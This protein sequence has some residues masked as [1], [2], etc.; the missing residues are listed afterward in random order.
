[1]NATTIAKTVTKPYRDA[2]ARKA[3]PDWLVTIRQGE[4]VTSHRFTE[5][6]AAQR[7]AREM[8]KQA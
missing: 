1:M 4:F 8:R 6:A 7:F 3:S 5:L 2:K